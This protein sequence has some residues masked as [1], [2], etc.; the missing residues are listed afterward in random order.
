MS[1]KPIPITCT[2]D[3]RLCH[4]PSCPVHS[5]GSPGKKPPRSVTDRAE[6]CSAFLAD[7]GCLEPNRT[8]YSRKDTAA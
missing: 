7:R 3:R 6:L 5:A 4:D 8:H 1:R 2:M